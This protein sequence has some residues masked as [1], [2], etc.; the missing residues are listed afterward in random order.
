MVRLIVVPDDFDGDDE[1]IAK[2]FYGKD[3]DGEAFVR[4]DSAKR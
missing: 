1:L 2:L 4:G 3:F